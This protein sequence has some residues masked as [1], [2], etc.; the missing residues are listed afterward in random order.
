M[1]Q[2][3]ED[4]QREKRESRSQ[5]EDKWARRDNNQEDTILM[6][7]MLIKDQVLPLKSQVAHNRASPSS[8][9]SCSPVLIMNSLGI[10][11]NA[12]NSGKVYEKEEEW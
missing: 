4:K 11:L 1:V 2:P 8:S 7:I 9:P 6:V 3:N 12:G 5:E 10:S